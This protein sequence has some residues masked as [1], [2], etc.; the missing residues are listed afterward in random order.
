MSP[1][2]KADR[3]AFARKRRRLHC[4][5]HIA[6]ENKRRRSWKQ[7]PMTAVLSYR[8]CIY[9]Y[10]YEVTRQKNAW[11]MGATVLGCHGHVL[12]TDCKRRF[13]ISVKA[14]KTWRKEF[15]PGCFSGISKWRSVLWRRSALSYRYMKYDLYWNYTVMIYHWNNINIT[16][17]VMTDWLD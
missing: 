17:S 7:T 12:N 4:D 13:F 2:S 5:A 14:Q 6:V 10:V 1:I 9:F 11:S 3:Q 15:Q 16:V 8:T